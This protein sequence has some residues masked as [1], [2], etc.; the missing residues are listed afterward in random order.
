LAVPFLIQ[1]FIGC[2]NFMVNI[3]LLISTW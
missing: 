3:S 1:I 2:S